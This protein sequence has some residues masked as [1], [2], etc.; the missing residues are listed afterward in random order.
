MKFRNSSSVRMTARNLLLAERLRKPKIGEMY[1]EA[2]VILLIILP[3][4]PK[5]SCWLFLLRVKTFYR[6]FFAHNI[7]FNNIPS[8]IIS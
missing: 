3:L 6:S 7:V 4:Y 8:L 5:T 2:E 1:E